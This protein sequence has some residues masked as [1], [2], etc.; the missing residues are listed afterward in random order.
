MMAIRYWRAQR[1]RDRTTVEWQK[2]RRRRWSTA[3]T[4]TCRSMGKYNSGQ[5]VLFWALVVLHGAAGPDRHPD[6]ARRSSTMPVDPRCASRRCC[7]RSSAF[8]LIV[9]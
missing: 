4:T 1:H 3:T 9:G 6:V 5:K 2:R 8:V 7:T